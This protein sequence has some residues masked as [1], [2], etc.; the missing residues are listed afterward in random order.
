[1]RLWKLLSVVLAFIAVPAQAAT[2]IGEGDAGPYADSFG[3]DVTA[4]GNYRVTVNFTA[5]VEELYLSVELLEIFDQFYP[6]DLSTSIGG[7]DVVAYP[8]VTDAGPLTS[9]AFTFA[10]PAPFYGEDGEFVTYTQFRLTGGTIEFFSD[11]GAGYTIAVDRMGGA[12]PEPATWAFL[13]LGFGAVGGAMRAS[14]R[15]TVRVAYA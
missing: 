10:V 2:I 1:M 15:R 8:F 3:L 6:D 5:P 9:A 14:R 12:I 7:N 13:I 4:P 11:N